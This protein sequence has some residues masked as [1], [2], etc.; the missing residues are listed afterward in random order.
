MRALGIFPTCCLPCSPPASKRRERGR[1]NR[2][3]TEEQRNVFVRRQQTFDM[4]AIHVMSVGLSSA[5]GC[6]CHYSSEV[7]FICCMSV[8]KGQLAAS[9]SSFLM[10]PPDYN[11]GGWHF[12]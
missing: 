8:L 9:L 4:V 5:T 10:P 11:G 6:S 3:K 12:I 2:K 1:E 7:G